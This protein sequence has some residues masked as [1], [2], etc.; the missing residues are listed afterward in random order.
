MEKRELILLSPYEVPAQ[1]P[2]MI[3]AEDTASFLNGFSALWH[4]AAIQGAA[5]PPRIDSPYEHEQPR[6]G[7]VYALPESP[8]LVLPEDWKVRARAA[9]AVFFYS[10]ADRAITLGKLLEA[11]RAQVEVAWQALRSG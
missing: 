10:G 6:A 8:P 11:L 1:N 7:Y 5:G 2:L 3:S 9:G 4:P